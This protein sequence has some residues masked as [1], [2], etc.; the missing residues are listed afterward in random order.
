MGFVFS[1]LF[2]YLVLYPIAPQHVYSYL[3]RFWRHNGLAPFYFIALLLVL[4]AYQDKPEWFC[5]PD[6]FQDIDPIA[7][8]L[9]T[10]LATNCSS[11][12]YWTTTNPW[13]PGWA[14]PLSATPWLTHQLKWQQ[15]VYAACLL[16]MV[17]ASF[18][19]P[20]L[21]PVYVATEPAE[22]QRVSSDSVEEIEVDSPMPV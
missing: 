11:T 19:F 5:R 18:I 20:C 7:C 12:V 21:L 13:G 16:A 8:I 10:P 14:L 2:G 9:N 6:I 1:V 15:V 17:L 22:V 4:A 3:A